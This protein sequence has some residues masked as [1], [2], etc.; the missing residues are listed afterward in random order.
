M[1][2]KNSKKI[3]SLQDLGSLLKEIKEAKRCKYIKR[4]GESCSLNNNCR[5]PDCGNNT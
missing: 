4:E 5:Y 2:K 1:S 3:N